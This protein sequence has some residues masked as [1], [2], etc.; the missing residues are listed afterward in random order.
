MVKDE[1]EFYSLTENPLKHHLNLEKSIY[2]I[3][4]QVVRNI[5]KEN[6]LL[7]NSLRN[8]L[9]TLQICLSCGHRQSKEDDLG[10]LTLRNET[11]EFSRTLSVT[12]KV[13]YIYEG[14]QYKKYELRLRPGEYSYQE[15]I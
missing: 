6:S 12:L 13:L 5:Y 9:K 10:V 1:E 14:D 11:D 15:I 4:N 8:K 3:M 7:G 2:E